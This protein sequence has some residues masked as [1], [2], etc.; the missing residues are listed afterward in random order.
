MRKILHTLAVALGSMG[1]LAIVWVM[2]MY[3]FALL[4]MQFF[5]GRFKFVKT[6]APRRSA[7]TFPRNGLVYSEGA[8]IYVALLAFM[9]VELM[10]VGMKAGL[11][12][13]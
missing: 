11:K 13:V 2:F 12:C 10:E 7:P 5:G 6:D 3:I 9:K 4:A 8:G 1:P